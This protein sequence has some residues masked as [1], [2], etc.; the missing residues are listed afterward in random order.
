MATAQDT[1]KG[2]I[3]DRVFKDVDLVDV[4]DPL[5]AT[6]ERDI[7]S[8]DIATPV[9][10]S[11]ASR[12]FTNIPILIVA[13]ILSVIGLVVFQTLETQ[14][15]AAQA[16]SGQTTTT[17]MMLSQ[18]IAKDAREAVL[19]EP[20]A[21]DRL[22]EQARLFTAELKTLHSGGSVR[23]L[24]PALPNV[25][26]TLKPLQRQ[27]SST[28]ESINTVLE[29][30]TVLLG[31]RD[32]VTR[33]NEL[34]PLLLTES[35]QVVEAVIRE[36]SNPEQVN[37][38]GRQRALGQ[39]IAKD[40][41]IFSKGGTGSTV[42]AT[43]FGKD[44]RLFAET[45]EDLRATS[46]PVVQA[47]LDT[48]AATFGELNIIVEEMLGSV[49]EF[50]QAH[51]AVQIIVDN[52]IPLLGAMQA[53]S[54]AYAAGSGQDFYRW[55][56]WVF[57]LSAAI[58]LILLVRA[59]VL[60]A[61]HRAE[62]N[63][64]Q[65]RETQDAILKLLDEMGDLADGDLTIEAEVTDQITGAIADSVNFAVREMRNLVRRINDASQLVATA[66]VDSVKTARQLS[67]VNEKQA[68]EITETTERIQAM[69]KSMEE[70]S[71]EARRSADVAKGSVNVAKQGAQA[72]RTNIRGM[73]EMRQQIQET[74][75][76]IKRLG[77][78]SQQIGD[79]VRLIDDIAEQTNILSLNAAIQAAMAGEAGRGFAVVA[80]EVQRLAERSTEATKQ[81]SELVKNIQSDT[82]EAIV[83]MEQATEGVVEG[84]RLADSAGQALGEIESVS[85]DLSR[86]ISSM[87]EAAQNQSRSATGVSQQMT[88]IREVTTSASSEARNTADSIGDLTDLARELQESVAGFK[89][90]V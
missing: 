69:A 43:Q 52:S 4:D 62:E 23:I 15:S 48:L 11:P 25:D 78:S 47:K 27:W 12:L 61:R 53:L 63:A 50:F 26:A 49:A 76:R 59:L 40:V 56:P 13:L 68:S 70:M 65:N 30:Q 28:R 72:V 21:F 82:N 31:T 89:I 29:Q 51:H 34:A 19:G 16:R 84:T 1:V 39:R 5:T 20:E 9:E 10:P 32:K 57:G 22:R 6:I 88:T 35:D 17:L 2:T 33:V 86:L 79:I 38:A 18:G 58:F 8:F 44:T 75:K 60:D 41:N 83:S 81:I 37:L 45:L 3:Q 74:S 71:T 46:G 55:L 42:S 85:E 36:S 90:P 67:K 24:A 54:N 64:R 80:D 87:A 77:E 7:S 14:R 73:G 66:S